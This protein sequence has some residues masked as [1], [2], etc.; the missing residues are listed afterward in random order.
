[1]TFTRAAAR[2]RE[3]MDFERLLGAIRLRHRGDADEGI[4]MDVGE[5]RLRDAAHLGIVREMDS[6]GGTLA[7]LDLERVAVDLFDRA[8]HACRSLRRSGAN[9]QQ[10]RQ[11]GGAEHRAFEVDHVTSSN[12]AQGLSHALG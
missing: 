2:F 9:R 12:A 7:G 6:D 10:K 1:M 5:C 8:A 3:D 4:L 11:S